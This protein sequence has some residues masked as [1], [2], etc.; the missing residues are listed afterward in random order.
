M[1]QAE[2]YRGLAT[3]NVTAIAQGFSTMWAGVAA[4]RRARR[5]RLWH[6][7]IS[8][9]QAGSESARTIH[10]SVLRESAV[11]D[12]PRACPFRASGAAAARAPSLRTPPPPALP[13]WLPAEVRARL[14]PR[15]ARA[16]V[17]WRPPTS[18]RLHAPFCPFP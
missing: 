12:G 13:A 15:Q 7:G 18:R 3:R 4:G 5:W 16:R 1:I 8:N 9:L 2:L 10:I 6:D 11:R 14:L 17:A